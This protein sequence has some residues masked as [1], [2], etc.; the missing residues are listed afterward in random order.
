MGR[1]G[2]WKGIAPRVGDPNGALLYPG[3]AGPYLPHV[4]NQDASGESDDPDLMDL[5]AE[6]FA[7]NGLI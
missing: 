5:P 2:C 4:D 6:A 3:E 7:Q 1:L